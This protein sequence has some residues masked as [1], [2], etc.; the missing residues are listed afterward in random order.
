MA[1]E[2]RGGGGP[3]YSLARRGPGLPGANS[4]G[5]EPR[6]VHPNRRLDRGGNASARRAAR[7]DRVLRA[8]RAIPPSPSHGILAAGCERLAESQADRVNGPPRYSGALP[9]QR[10]RDSLDLPEP[11]AADGDVFLRL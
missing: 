7:A 2:W 3:A 5:E 9:G 1:R 10:R 6:Q 11:P 8:P 4:A